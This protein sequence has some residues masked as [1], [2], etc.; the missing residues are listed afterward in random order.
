M[1]G[2]QRQWCME[3]ITHRYGGQ[4]SIQDVQETLF[5]RPNLLQS[6]LPAVQ[7]AVYCSNPYTQKFFG[8]LFEKATKLLISLAS[9]QNTQNT[10]HSVFGLSDFW[11]SGVPLLFFPPRNH[12][13]AANMDPIIGNPIG[14]NSGMYMANL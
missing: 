1:P 11:L 10:C 3:F 13:M 9:A 4:P 8:G 5:L 6:F 7:R 14:K 2:C 12:F